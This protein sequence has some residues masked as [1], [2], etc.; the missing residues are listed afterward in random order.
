VTREL[1][2]PAQLT[3]PAQRRAFRELC[4]LPSAAW[5]LPEHAE[6]VARL[7]LAR[8]QLERTPLDADEWLEWADVV[9][10]LELELL[11]T[12]GALAGDDHPHS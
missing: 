9:F 6:L 4:R 1:E 8:E 3:T 2:P 11:L 7:V 10:E 5:W 12:P